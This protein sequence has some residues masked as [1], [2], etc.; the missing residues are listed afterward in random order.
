MPL[1]RFCAL[2]ANDIVF[3]DSS[4][5][6]KIGSDVVYEFL[7][8]LPRLKAGV[9]VHFHDI[10]LPAEYPKSWVLEDRRFW[11]EQ[12]LLQAFLA[13][14]SAFEVMMAGSFLH[15]SHSE[16][17]KAAFASYDPANVWPGSFWMR[18]KL[19]N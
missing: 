1:E 18:R 7:E 2:E 6:V 19:P 13:F 15:L 11:N 9:M 14:N 10:F 8:L 5:V 3:I 12:Y 4:H 16:K 17:L